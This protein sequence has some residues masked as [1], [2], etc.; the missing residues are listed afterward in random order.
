M[1][2]WPWGAIDGSGLVGSHQYGRLEDRWAFQ[3]AQAPGAHAVC[4]GPLGLV[5]PC[6]RDRTLNTPGLRGEA[7]TATEGPQA[8]VHWPL[9]GAKHSQ[10]GHPLPLRLGLG[11]RVLPT[12][13]V[14]RGGESS[15]LSSK[16]IV[17]YLHP[18]THT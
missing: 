6:T 3:V 9:P 8:Q 15:G 2:R 4:I 12:S 5:P 11:I 7:V 17:W 1:S 10:R 16:G 18:V 13:I 14:V